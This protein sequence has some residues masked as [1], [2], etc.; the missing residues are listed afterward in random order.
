MVFFYSTAPGDCDIVRHDGSYFI[1]KFANALREGVSFE[2]IAKEV[3]SKIC[4]NTY[5]CFIDGQTTYMK[6][7]PHLESSLRKNLIF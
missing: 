7:A 3:T 6:V 1:K 5:E 4:Q 2:S